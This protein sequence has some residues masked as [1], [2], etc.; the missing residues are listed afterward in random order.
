[1]LEKKIYLIE[2]ENKEVIKVVEFVENELKKEKER[3]VEK[4]EEFN[5][6]KELIEEECYKNQDS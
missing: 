2:F 3:N 4:D 5:K 6:F 1:M